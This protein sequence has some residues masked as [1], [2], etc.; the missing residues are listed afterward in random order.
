M[1]SAISLPRPVRVRFQPVMLALASSLALVL[2]VGCYE[3]DLELGPTESAKIDPRFVGDWDFAD[4]GSTEVTRLVVRNFDGRQY[5]VAW[6]EAKAEPVRAAAFTAEVGGA[7]FAHVRGLTP[8]NDVSGK[9]FLE[10]IGLTPDGKLSIR[11]LKGEFFEGK[12][13]KTSA[14]LRKLV[15]A[16]VNNEAMYDPETFYGTRVK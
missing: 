14:Q 16:N 6:D 8:E 13:V 2:L 7:T 15:E 4:K 9:H 11:H 5:Y 10:R 3:T 12:E 1:P